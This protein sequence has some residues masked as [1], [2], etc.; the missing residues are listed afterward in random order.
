MGRSN[1]YTA[2]LFWNAATREI[3]EYS[4]NS[5]LY[6]ERFNLIN[7]ASEI[8]QSLVA[9]VVSEAYMNDFLVGIPGTDKQLVSAGSY[10]VATRK[11]TA[12]M[13]V[14]FSTDDVSATITFVDGATNYYGIVQS[15]VD[16]NNVILRDGYGNL[17]VANIASLTNVLLQPTTLNY[18]A[19]GLTSFRMLRYGS[20]IKMQ[21]M[22]TL[23]SAVIPFSPE[24]FERWV[25]TAP[26]NRN[27]IAWSFVGTTLYLKK[28]S[29]LASFGTVTLRFPT[30]PDLILSDSETVDLLDGGMVHSGIMI[31]KNLI[32]KRLKVRPTLNVDELTQQVQSVYRSMGG[33][34]KKEQ[35]SQKIESL[36]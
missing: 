25:T 18:S 15:F 6:N 23:A 7:S 3:A 9:D 5:L 11:I 12:T 16:A 31:L 28:G 35:I 21:V 30:L 20:Q 13:N 24:S 2:E 14:A 29:S 33:E 8:A 36:L 22:S 26:Q 19:L 4:Q 34:V 10:A 17:P 32:Q 27:S 1:S